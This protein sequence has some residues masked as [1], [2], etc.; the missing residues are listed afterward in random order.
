MKTK[1]TECSEMLAH[2]IQ[3][4]GNYPEESIQ[5]S[6]HG[7]SFKLRKVNISFSETLLQ[8]VVCYEKLSLIFCCGNN[9]HWTFMSGIRPKIYL[10]VTTEC[11]DTDTRKTTYF[12]KFLQTTFCADIYNSMLCMSNGCIYS[13]NKTSW[14][15]KCQL[16]I[17]L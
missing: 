5:H 6:E 13:L 2:K 8:I 15:A 4:P 7:E 3:K 12:T 11:R 14:G 16:L 10:T 9:E 17:F 1:Q